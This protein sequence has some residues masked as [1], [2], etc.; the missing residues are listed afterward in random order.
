M[1]EQAPQEKRPSVLVVEDDDDLLQMLAESMRAEGLVARTARNG[2]EALASLR[3]NSDKPC[4]IV[5]DLMMPVMNGWELLDHLCVDESLSRIP[6][7][8]VTAAASPRVAEIH[9]TGE[10]GCRTDCP[11]GPPGHGVHLL[12]KPFAMDMLLGLA[13]RYCRP[14]ESPHPNENR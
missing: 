3:E 6:V 9:E 13:R 4:L 2:V 14:H 11:T 7:T 5:L 10:P 12:R 1:P 8:V